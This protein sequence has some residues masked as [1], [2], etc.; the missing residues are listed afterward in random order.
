ME[1]LRSA[2]RS[3][4]ETTCLDDKGYVGERP[5]QGW[6]VVHAHDMDR[7]VGQLN[8]Y[9]EQHGYGYTINNLQFCGKWNGL[10]FS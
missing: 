4:T 3:T 9:S 2:G 6:Y 8:K 7:L 5:L 10:G 1:D